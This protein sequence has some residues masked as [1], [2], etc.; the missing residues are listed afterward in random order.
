M[1]DERLTCTAMVKI[2]D[3]KDQQGK[4]RHYHRRCGLPASEVEIGGL[5]TKAK[6]VLCSRHKLL[7]DRQA[8]ISENGYPL[9]KVK[10]DLKKERYVQPRLDGTGVIT[11]K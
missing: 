4:A 10:K 2:D 5:L 9:G 11:P 7:A 8:F 6:A 1:A 3:G